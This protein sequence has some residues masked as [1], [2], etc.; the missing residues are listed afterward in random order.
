MDFWPS[1]LKD[2]A[3]GGDRF[4]I[5]AVMGRCVS[6]PLMLP[7]ALLEKLSTPGS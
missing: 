4:V 7:T 3:R 6:M 5:S 1:A 2:I